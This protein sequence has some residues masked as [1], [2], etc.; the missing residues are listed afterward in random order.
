MDTIFDTPKGCKRLLQFPSPSKD[1]HAPVKQ[2][3]KRKLLKEDVLKAVVSIYSYLLYIRLSPRMKM[4]ARRLRMMIREI[5]ALPV[6]MQRFQIIMFS[7][8][9]CSCMCVHVTVHVYTLES[10][11]SVC[12]KIHNA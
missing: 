10:M 4:I 3:R 2:P 5:L 6:Q 7:Y 8:L 11:A 1:S 12:K 9:F